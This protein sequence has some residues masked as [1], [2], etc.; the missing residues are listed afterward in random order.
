M[1]QNVKQALEAFAEKV[2]SNAKRELGTSKPRK[3]YKAKWRRGKV[4]SFQ[5]KKKKN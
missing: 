1:S 2:V 4:V 5:I 3:S